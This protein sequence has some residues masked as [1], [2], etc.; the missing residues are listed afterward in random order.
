ML[1]AGGG[2]CRCPDR[3]GQGV[4]G[5]SSGPLALAAE[6]PL[7]QSHCQDT[8]WCPFPALPRLAAAPLQGWHPAFLGSLG[9]DAVLVGWCPRA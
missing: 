4:A 7:L 8:R 1:C 6:G 5:P 9:Q 3:R 2:L